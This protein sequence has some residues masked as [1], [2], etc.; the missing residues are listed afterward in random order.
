MVAPAGSSWYPLVLRLPLQ[1]RA[2]IYSRVFYSW[3][4]YRVTADTAVNEYADLI[5]TQAS[6]VME[7]IAEVRVH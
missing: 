1:A 5:A 7:S 3:E 2:E 6:S 4:Y